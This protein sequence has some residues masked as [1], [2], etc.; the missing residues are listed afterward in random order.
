MRKHY[1]STLEDILD[2]LDSIVDSFGTDYARAHGMDEAD[3]KVLKERVTDI[4]RDLQSTYEDI[5]RDSDEMYRIA[6]ELY[7]LSR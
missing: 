5:S 6:D 4:A 3:L 1:L 2:R 7:D